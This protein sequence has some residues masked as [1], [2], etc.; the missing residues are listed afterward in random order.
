MVKRL[1]T[2][3]VLLALLSTALYFGGYVI[4]GAILLV[5][6]AG[7][8]EMQKAMNAA[9]FKVLPVFSYVYAVVSSV[10]CVFMPTYISLFALAFICV[11]VFSVVFLKK[12]NITGALNS[13]KL[14]IYPVT[15]LLPIILMERAGM[16]M[17]VIVAL[18]AAITTDTFAYCVGVLIGKHKLCPHIS[19]NKTIEG[20]IGGT[21]FCVAAVTLFG[22]FLV[23]SEK[24]IWALLSWILVGFVA[25]VFSQIGDL[26]ASRIKRLCNVKDFGSIFP[27]HGGIMDRIDS[28]TF[29][30]TV[31][32]VFVRLKLI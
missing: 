19:P 5:S 12:E 4:Y 15:L 17:Y 7:I 10:I 9:G 14:C 23:S 25:S 3:I 26:F 18:I 32:Y 29:A 30:V 2:M 16:R 22:Y 27:G 28:I 20:A 31:I 1:I 21:V 11:I 13:I 6:L 24:G 8:Y